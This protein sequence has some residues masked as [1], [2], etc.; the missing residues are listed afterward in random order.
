[1][2]VSVRE[3]VCRRWGFCGSVGE[4]DGFILRRHGVEVVPDGGLHGAV[5][6]VAAVTLVGA[7][8][9]LGG[10]CPFCQRGILP[11]LGA[12]IPCPLVFVPLRRALSMVAGRRVAGVEFFWRPLVELVGETR[13]WVL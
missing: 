4:K 2:L 11:L 7:G 5:G 12:G 13:A 1:M 6:L 9:L 8:M 3:G 10:S